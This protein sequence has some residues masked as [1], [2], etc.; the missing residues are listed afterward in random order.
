M[1]KGCKTLTDSLKLDC[2]N[3]DS[4]EFS[5]LWNRRLGIIIILFYFFFIFNKKRREF[6]YNI[7]LF[8]ILQNF[9]KCVKDIPGDR[10][11]DY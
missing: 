7:N 4:E 1:N 6:D 3:S 11:V 10:L 9:L 2:I 5:F 8:T